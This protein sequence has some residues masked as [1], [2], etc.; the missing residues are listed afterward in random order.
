MNTYNYFLGNDIGKST[1]AVCVIDGQEKRQLELSI[2]NTSEG[3]KTLLDK[4][5]TLPD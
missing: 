5:Q 2:P 1:V 3:M 4:L